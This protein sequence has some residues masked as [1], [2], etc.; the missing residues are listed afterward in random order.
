MLQEDSFTSPD[1][2]TAPKGA[3]LS[4]PE[5]LRFEEGILEGTSY[6]DGEAS[7]G[8]ELRW[9]GWETPWSATDRREARWAE[10]EA[11]VPTS[12]PSNGDGEAVDLAG[13]EAQQSTA[14]DSHHRR[15]PRGG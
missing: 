10:L 3:A 13:F 11:S 12:V 9:D 1:I 15:A 6:L 2:W 5:H 7:T 4:F 8:S 14:V